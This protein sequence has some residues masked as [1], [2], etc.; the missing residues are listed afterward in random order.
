MNNNKANSLTRDEKINV[1]LDTITEKRKLRIANF[2]ADQ[3]G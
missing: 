1:V 3:W 2:C